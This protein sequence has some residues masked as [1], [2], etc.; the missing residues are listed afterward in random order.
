M[1]KNNKVLIFVILVFSILFL[2]ECKSKN[3]E[4]KD[5]SNCEFVYDSP[6]TK[7][8]WTAFKFTEKTGVNGTFSEFKV[9]GMET[10]KSIVEAVQN[11]KFSIDGSKVFTSVRERD[12]KIA[13]SF[14]G[15]MEGGISGYFKNIVGT[16]SGTADLFLTMNGV[17][18]KVP[19]QFTIK[20]QKELELKASIN[21]EDWNAADSIKAL[22]KVCSE[23]HTGKN[24]ESKLWPD[25]NIVVTTT[26]KTKCGL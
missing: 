5:L 24:K 6:A 13:E 18:K 11:V 9:D 23:Q 1:Q 12:A 8:Q 25:V 7:L 2:L 20:N 4:S 19:A 10:K 26:F 16:D 17:E 22:N 15:T 14:F 21:V 3:E